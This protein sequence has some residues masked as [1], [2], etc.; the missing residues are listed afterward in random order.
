MSTQYTVNGI[1]S[2]LFST[3]NTKFK[4]SS[5]CLGHRKLTGFR[6]VFKVLESGVFFRM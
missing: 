1:V 5:S 3:Q 2:A 6:R 4:P